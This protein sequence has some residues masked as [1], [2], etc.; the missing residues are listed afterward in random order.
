MLGTLFEI[1][2]ALGGAAAIVIAAGW[3]GQKFFESRLSRDL[4]QHKAKLSAASAGEL[5]KLRHDLSAELDR[6]LKLIAREFDALTHA[7]DLI[8]TAAG[9]TELATRRFRQ[10]LDV[11]HLPDD[12]LREMLNQI[13]TTEHI[14]AAILSAEQANRQRLYQKLVDRG[15]ALNA[16]DKAASA[17]NYLV[18]QSI[19]IERHTYDTLVELALLIENAA[20]EQVEEQNQPVLREGRFARSDRFRAEWSNMM[21]EAEAAVR[22]RLEHE[23]L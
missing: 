22:G 17:R 4:E 16:L 3:I 10:Y 2:K 8:H 6:R 11:A 19:F 18:G 13:E 1:I 23:R 7:W 12:A 14:K 15:Q 5:E 9:A 20:I 21:R